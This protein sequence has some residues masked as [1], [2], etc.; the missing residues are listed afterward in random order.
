MRHILATAVAFCLGV[1]L[2]LGQEVKTPPINDMFSAVKPLA[3]QNSSSYR[4][5]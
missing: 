4:E 5:I 1:T 2:A 3:A